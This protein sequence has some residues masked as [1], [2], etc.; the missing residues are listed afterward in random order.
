MD[1]SKL[2]IPTL[3]G[4]NWGLYYIALQAAARIL[5]IWDAMRGEVLATT[6]PKLNLLVKPTPVTA[7]ATAAEIAA[8]TAAKTIWS[9]KN[10]QGLGLIQAMVSPV[11]WQNYNTLGTAKEVLNILE[12]T[13]RAVG[14]ASTYLQLVNM[15]KIQF[16]NSMD[17]LPQIQVFQDNHNWITLNGHSR[18]S[19][20]LATFMFC[21]SLP[22]LYKSTAQQYLDNITVIANYQI[23]D[24]IARVLQ[25]ESRRKAQALGQGSSLNKLSTMKNIGKK[26][27]KCSKTNH[28]TQNHWPRGKN[29]NKK[30]RGQQ[31]S[32]KSSNSSGK[33][34]R[35]RAKKRHKQVPMY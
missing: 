5:D 12:T 31:K 32:Q 26:C 13:F 4:P 20:D 7:N 25:E 2:C 28:M 35:G 18:L 24:I 33:I 16:A 30:G 9:K 23:S 14:G 11:I 22:D 21:S 6:P 10:A 1:A 15:V 8:Y 27:A 19:E 17:L 34:K 29:P 3:N